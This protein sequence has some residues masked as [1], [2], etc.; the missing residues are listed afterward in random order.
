MKKKTFYTELCY[1]LGLLLPAFSGAMIEKADFGLSMIVAPAYILH[2]K[3]SQ[4]HSFFT[5]GVCTYLFEGFLLALMCLIIR[6][7]K[8]SYLF[9]FV[10]AVI[11]GYLL[12]ASVF[13]LSGLDASALWVRILLYFAGLVICDVGIALIFRTYISSEVYELFVKEISNKFHLNMSR[14]K[15]I[16][17]LSSLL[18]AVLL[19]LLLL[20]RLDGIGWGTLVCALLN[21]VLIGLFSG[22]FDRHWEFKDALPLRRFFEK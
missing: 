12:D 2:L 19:A 14:F 9:S 17:D 6:R 21:G 18:L 1:A 5:F 16:Y 8:V 3:L 13:L 4:L 7:F 10:T 11:Y 20:G 22:W 15:M